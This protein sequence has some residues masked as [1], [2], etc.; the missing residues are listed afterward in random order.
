MIVLGMSD[1]VNYDASTVLYINEKLVYQRL[2][3]KIA[4]LEH[5]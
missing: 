4:L 5:R 2:C 1:A 3:M